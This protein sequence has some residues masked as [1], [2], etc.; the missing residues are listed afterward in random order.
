MS[1]HKLDRLFNEK[2]SNQEV[3]PSQEAW[4]LL[5]ERLT[6]KK[7][8]KAYL[9]Y[10]AAIILLISISAILVIPSYFDNHE[11]NY[12]SIVVD[13]PTQESFNFNW[14][15]K[16]VEKNKMVVN[17]SQQQIA[18]SEN[19]T[20]NVY[21]QPQPATKQNSE[22]AEYVIAKTETFELESIR[23]ISVDVHN[24]SFKDQIQPFSVNSPTVKIK[25]IAE[26]DDKAEDKKLKKIINYARANSPVD[27]LADI[28][29]AKDQF[30]SEKISLD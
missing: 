5:N 30:I 6:H 15:L 29:N 23:K 21:S 24:I 3:T 2:L 7:N 27:I 13:R 14:N 10:A 19:Q 22:K 28:R 16:E 18:A 12:A 9:K 26:N 17:S 1:T 11:D 20:D 25:Y 4:E 8:N